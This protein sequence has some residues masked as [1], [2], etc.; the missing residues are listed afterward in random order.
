MDYCAKNGTS[1][2]SAPEVLEDCLVPSNQEY[3][4]WTD[5]KCAG[6]NGDCGYF[7]PA[8]PAYHGFG[9]SAKA[10]L[11]EFSMPHDGCNEGLAP[12]TPSIWILN[13]LIPRTEQYGCSCWESGC[14]ELDLFEVLTHSDERMKAT[15]HD[16][17]SYGCS[18]WFARPVNGFAKAAVIMQ[19]YSITI[20]MLPDDF[21]IGSPLTANEINQI[22][23][24]PATVDSLPN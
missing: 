5:K 3:T 4:I 14:G 1:T 21:D 20:A 19:N 12:D 15:V 2:A 18:D 7:N 24:M 13:S 23:S 6:Q 9:G 10:F 17:Q 16:Q 22:H 11:F 8:V